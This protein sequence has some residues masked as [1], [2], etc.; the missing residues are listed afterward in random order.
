MNKEIAKKQKCL[1]IR[2]NV[3]V[4]MDEEK[5]QK[6]EFALKNSIGKF[7]EIEGRIINTADIVGIFLPADLED[8]KRRKNGQWKCE[9]GNW[10]NRGDDCECYKIK[11]RAEN[12]R[13]LKEM[14]ESRDMSEEERLNGLKK[15]RGMKDKIFNK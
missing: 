4:W 2:N 10:H 1:M 8:L 3:E 12:E 11:A 14:A 13:K 15:F 6:L 9:Y 7:V 5:W